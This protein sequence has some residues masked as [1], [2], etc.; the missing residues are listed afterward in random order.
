MPIDL[1]C[2]Y[3][4]NNVNVPL[5]T[6]LVRHAYGPRLFQR[7]R[8]DVGRVNKAMCSGYSIG[9]SAAEMMS[10]CHLRHVRVFRKF[11]VVVCGPSITHWWVWLFTKRQQIGPL[12][13]S[14][15]SASRLFNS[16]C[17]HSRHATCC[18]TSFGHISPVNLSPKSPNLDKIATETL[19]VGNDSHTNPEQHIKN[20][21]Q[22]K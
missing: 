18:I 21:E 19:F 11:Q 7:W 13:S 6:L 1:R 3:W 5:V 16:R 10:K 15:R 4:N 17:R 8:D 12:K 9:S 20:I 14:W 22:S 2:G